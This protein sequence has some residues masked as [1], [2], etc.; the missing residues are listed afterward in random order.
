MKV[1]N[2]IKEFVDRSIRADVCKS[3]APWQR[4]EVERI[5]YR[6]YLKGLNKK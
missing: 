6:A 4:S 5:A 2:H 1:P 3:L